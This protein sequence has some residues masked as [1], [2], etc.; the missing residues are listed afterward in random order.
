MDSVQLK[1]LFDSQAANYDTQWVRMKAMNEALYF[2]LESVFAELPADA[3][4]LCVGVA[5][6][7]ELINLVQGHPHWRFTALERPGS[8]LDLGRGRVHE[9]DRI[10]PESPAELRAPGVR[11]L[12]HLDHRRAECE[13][14]ARRKILRPQIEID[15]ELISGQWP[16]F[17]LASDERDDADV[18]QREL[19]RVVH[20]L[21]RGLC[22]R[23]P[24]IAYET[25][26]QVEH[27][28][29]ENF[30]L[31]LCRPADDEL[32]GPLGRR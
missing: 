4:V 17:P 3:R 25:L 7:T 23:P 1:A 15:I 11:R 26:V 8:V 9:A 22:T 30:A 31:A 2:L 28:F 32:H 18:H 20:G 5:T 27:G 29:L 12:G 21:L 14:R 10:R 13:A 16:A 6:G 19:C 24:A